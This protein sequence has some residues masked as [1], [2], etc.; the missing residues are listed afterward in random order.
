VKVTYVKK[1]DF[2]KTAPCSTVK[3]TGV[4][5]ILT[6]IF[7]LLMEAASCFETSVNFHQNALHN[8]P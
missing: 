1:A 3:F 2:W 7:V 4:S 5:E 8:I 6:A